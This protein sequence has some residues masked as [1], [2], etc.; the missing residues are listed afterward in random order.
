MANS[1]A[2]P[3]SA[4][5][6]GLGQI[7]MGYDFAR[8]PDQVFSH[9]RAFATHPAFWLA[10]GVDPDPSRR[11][12]FTER[13]GAPAFAGADEA[14]AT[15]QPD[16]VAVATPT[17]THRQ[18][19]AV[20][21]ELARPRAILC[22]KPLAYSLGD[23]RWMVTRCREANVLLAVNYMR[24][25]D[26]GVIDIHGR[27]RAGEIRGAVKG[28]CWYSKGLLHNGSHFFNLLTYWL[29][30]FETHVTITRGRTLAGGD[31]EPDFLARFQGGEVVFLAARE[32]MY[33]H[34]GIELVTDTGRLRYERAG[35]RITWEPAV[36]DALFAGHRSLADSPQLV[37]N[38]MR[39]F[40]WNVADQLAAAVVGKAAYFSTGDD[41]LAT[42]ESLTGILKTS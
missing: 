12:R 31:G 10:G 20:V 8:E 18:M 3:L 5:V 14:L 23:A 30:P 1:I 42:L 29:G 11:A 9:A 36:A 32:E 35:H 15:T 39:R 28:T 41:A 21:L 38:D 26:P 25:S 27:L 19:L 34:Y 37:P 33:S 7:G 40:Q 24:R 16:V 6:V 13:F 17:D 4:L 22:E 2:P